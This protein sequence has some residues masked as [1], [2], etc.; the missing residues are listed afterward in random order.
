MT[1]QERMERVLN[2]LDVMLRIAEKGAHGAALL[3]DK[4][5]M[6]RLCKD[7][8]DAR[9]IARK[10]HF[11]IEDAERYAVGIIDCPTCGGVVAESMSG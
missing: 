8:R 4:V 3:D 9:T 11:A 1:A 7:L 6:Q 2:D 5:A 10:S